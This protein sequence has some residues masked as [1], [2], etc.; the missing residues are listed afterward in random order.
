MAP[1]LVPLPPSTD[2]L[3]PI[4]QFIALPLAWTLGAVRTTL[5]GLCL[6]L[7]AVLV[8]GLLSICVSFEPQQE[9]RATA[10]LIYILQLVIPPLHAI[11]SRALTAILARVVLF[12]LGFV[13]NQTET[14]S[15]KRTA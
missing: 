8:E 3:P 4:V 7:Q 13:W 1:F 10:N 12:L 14:V 5:I 9:S 11:F 15:L 2:S 6:L